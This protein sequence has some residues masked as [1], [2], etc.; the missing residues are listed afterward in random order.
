MG[1]QTG[2][3]PARSWSPSE[4]ELVLKITR[5]RATL[6]AVGASLA[7]VGCESAADT[8]N[9]NLSTAAENFEVPRRIIGINTITG[10]VLFE[11]TGFC[12]YETN[13]DVV[14]AICAT[15]GDDRQDSVE[16]TTLGLSDNVTFLSTQTGPIGV[17][18]FQPRVIFRPETILPDFDLS[19]SGN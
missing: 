16:R 12:S 15:E 9:R 6:V 10:D 19:T 7:L 3:R 1:V 8:A 18:F 14:E 13:G 5:T 2:H 17:D 4:Q 11:V